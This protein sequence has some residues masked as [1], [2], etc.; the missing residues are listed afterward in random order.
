[1]GGVVVSAGATTLLGSRL[2]IPVVFAPVGSMELFVEG[3][4]ASAAEAACRFGTLPILSS[5][6]APGIE[7]TAAAHPGDKWF[8]LYVRGDDAW[9][10][11]RVRRARQAGYTGLVLTV[12]TAVYSIRERQIAARWLPPTKRGEEGPNYQ[13][14]FDWDAAA[15]LRDAARMPVII[16]GVQ[17]AEDAG[18]CIERGF[19]AIYVSNHGGRQL[20]HALGSLDALPEIVDIVNGRV[21]VIVDGGVARGS[22]V[23]KAVALG[24]SAV[25]VGRLQA[26]AVAAAGVAGGVRLLEILEK[27]IVTTLALLGAPSLAEINPSYLRAVAPPAQAA[28]PFPHLPAHIKP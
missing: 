16:K 15:R 9:V 26:Y 28:G 14:L 2:R 19:D 4:A 24:A 25:G 3:G 13:A 11:E 18:L 8:Q 10:A 17:T 22:D 6:T 5:V 21:P 12:D 23:V 20:D 7:A 1:V 27:E